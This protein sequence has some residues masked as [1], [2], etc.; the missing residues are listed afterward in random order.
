MV[1]IHVNKQFGEMKQKQ[2]MLNLLQIILVLFFTKVAA[3][4][5][6]TILK[7]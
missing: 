7:S 1:Y 6:E 5:N 2:Q 4:L 3:K